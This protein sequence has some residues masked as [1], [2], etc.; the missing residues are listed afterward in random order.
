MDSDELGTVELTVTCAHWRTVVDHLDERCLSIVRATLEQG[1]AVPWLRS[2]EVS[3][4]LGGDDELRELNHR[5]RD[6]D[7]A[8]NVLSFPTFDA[9]EG[10]MTDDAPAGPVLLGDVAISLQRL[11]AETAS[12]GKTVLD[13]FAHLLVHGVLH[14]LGYDHLNDE[15][16]ETM[17]AMEEAILLSI[18]IVAPYGRG[19]ALDTCKASS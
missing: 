12:S 5:Y 15:Q 2:G 14:L 17:E 7:Q 3:L 16:A 4:L 19:A 6:R 10:Q 8:T 1:T 11:S 9:D 18:G 13:H